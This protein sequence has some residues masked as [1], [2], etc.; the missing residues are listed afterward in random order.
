MTAKKRENETLMSKSSPKSMKIN[1][2]SMWPLKNK[3]FSH[4]SE[5]PHSEPSEES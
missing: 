1:E 4:E 2:G 3:L 5:I